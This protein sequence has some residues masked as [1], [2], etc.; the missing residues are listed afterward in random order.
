MAPTQ[1]G[2]VPGCSVEH[3]IIKMVHFILGSMDGDNKSAVMGIPVDYSK[4]YNRM[5]HSNIITIMSDLKEPAIPICAI[6]LTKS[7]LTQRSMCVRYKGAE[8][9]FEKCPG[10][11]PQGGLLTGLLFCL[12]VNRAGSPCPVRSLAEP[13]AEVGHNDAQ[14]P[15]GERDSSSGLEPEGNYSPRMEEDPPEAE[16]EE[17]GLSRMDTEEHQ[18]HGLGIEEMNATRMYSEDEETPRLEVEEE[19][20][21]RLEGEEVAPLCQNT[22]K[23]H[24][25]AYIDDL[26]L[27][28]KISLQDLEKEVRIIGPP[29]FHGRFH[30]ELPPQK[31]ILQHQL[32]DLVEY[33]TSN[34]MILNSKKT[35]CIPFNNSLTK[36]FIPKY[37]VDGQ[38]NLEVIYS[39]KLVGLVI[40]SELTWKSHIEYTVGRVNK[41][42]WQ[43]TRFKQH[44][45]D[46]KMLV[47]FYILKIRS[48]L[49]FG[50]VCY[51]SSL[52]QENTRQLEL[53]QKRSLACILGS[54]YKSYS[55]ALE[56]TM[57]PRLDKLR[58]DACV[59]WAM[60]AQANPQHTQ[61][62]PINHSQVETRNRQFFKEYKCKGAK[63]FNSAVPHMVRTLNSLQFHPA[64]SNREVTII[65]NSGATI[66]V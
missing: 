54:E 7:Y 22:A 13:E 8:S 17:E 16:A 1:L 51:H 3:Y 47:K 28:E 58:E 37:S 36:D 6:K 11:G 27:L 29:Q 23:T 32:H 45:A 40:T 30:L 41:I 50:A 31:S 15:D 66:I 38:T 43:L 39:L 64:G 24:K 60:K 65:T 55:H 53:Q 62:F 35:R 14:R 19:A 33:T 42:I 61:L 4:A 20:A 2:G 34:H 18:V 21:P 59:K 9:S 63:Y 57:L 52:T 48:V 56:V 10:G 44:G 12:Q 26:T 46:M 5:L 49:M 25:K